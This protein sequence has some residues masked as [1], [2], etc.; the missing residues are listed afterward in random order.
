[1]SERDRKDPA[2]I[3]WR[4]DL[5][6]GVA[7]GEVAVDR[8]MTDLG[9]RV[10]AAVEAKPGPIEVGDL[11][12]IMAGVDDALDAV[13]PTRAGRSSPLEQEVIRLTGK[14]VDR[15]LERGSGSLVRLIRSS[16]PDLAAI[17]DRKA[18]AR[19][20]ALPKGRRR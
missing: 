7:E 9:K 12:S 18:D 20:K 6:R 15:S 3:P 11:R 2:S 8:M 1:M 4:H 5:A 17:L 14:A 10:R 16:H 13:Y 19:R